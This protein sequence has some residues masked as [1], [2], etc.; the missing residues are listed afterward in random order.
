MA[1]DKRY[2]VNYGNGQ[3]SETCTLMEAQRLKAAETTYA[4]YCF[5][6]KRTYGTADQP[7]DWFR[8]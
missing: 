2:R 7:G 4:A 8:L 1:T 5:I 6:E 3:V